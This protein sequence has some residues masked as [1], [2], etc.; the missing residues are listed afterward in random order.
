MV[1]NTILIYWLFCHQGLLDMFLQTH[2]QGMHQL[3]LA[4]SKDLHALH[5]KPN[6]V[7]VFLQ[8]R[9][10]SWGEV[11]GPSKAAVSAQTA[12]QGSRTETR[13][14]WGNENN[15]IPD[16]GVINLS[17]RQIDSIKKANG[18]NKSVARPV[19]QYSWYNFCQYFLAKRCSHV[20]LSSL[21][22]SSLQIN[23]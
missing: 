6:S 10:S 14:C 13:E 20:R 17:S 18:K 16:E 3:Y 15:N 21:P 22:S 12:L 23:L 4:V 2:N 9:F 11:D 7:L 19:I 8:F 1:T 5:N